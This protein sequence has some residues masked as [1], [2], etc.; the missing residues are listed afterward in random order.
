M[1]KF[2]LNIEQHLNDIQDRGQGQLRAILC[3]QYPIYC[4]HAKILDSTPEEM[5]KFDKAILGLIRTNSLDSQSM[6]TILGTSKRLVQGRVNSMVIEGFI[7]DKSNSLTDRGVEFLQS[8]T[9][10]RFKKRE[11]D[12][13]LDGTSLKPLIKEFAWNNSSYLISEDDYSY[14][15]KRNGDTRIHRPF[16]PD[17]V[18]APIGVEKFEEQLLGLTPEERSLFG[19]PLGLEQVENFSFTMLTLPVLVSLSDN[20]SPE[21]FVVNGFNHT[22]DVEYLKEIVTN[23]ESK[24]DGVMVQLKI[25]KTRGDGNKSDNEYPVVFNNWFEVDKSD[26]GHNRI[27]SFSKEDFIVALKKEY[28]IEVYE[29][30]KV[31]C[32]ESELVVNLTRNMLESVA[33]AGIHYKTKQPFEVRKIIEN[34]QRGRDYLPGSPFGY[35][36][37]LIFISFITEDEFVKYACDVL[38]AYDSSEKE[39]LLKNIN[40][41]EQPKDISLRKV[42]IM[43]GLYEVLEQMD[44]DKYMY[45]PIQ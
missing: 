6:A 26:F 23:M 35:G 42:L 13:Y 43:L 1:Q 18:H 33:S 28:G 27:F 24:L 17:L 29:N 7:I 3:L 38:N 12:F 37:W 45:K 2:N 21:K 39:S 9:E 11:V 30:E 10:K 32:Q 14:V 16:A 22:G 34:V 20:G 40:L 25:D 36:V 8:G 15:T 4:I 19:V 5:D 31:F 44:M 41:I